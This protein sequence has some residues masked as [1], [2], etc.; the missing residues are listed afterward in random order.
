MRERVITYCD[1]CSEEI[2][3]YSYT[4]LTLE[5]GKVLDFHSRDKKCFDK[6][7]ESQQQVK[8]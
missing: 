6:Y 7:K 5:D 4:S 3:D 8:P 2:D 1:F